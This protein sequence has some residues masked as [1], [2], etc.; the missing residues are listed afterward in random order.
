MRFNYYLTPSC[1]KR[2]HLVRKVPP[3][4]P[5]ARGDKDL[6]NWGGVVTVRV[7]SSLILG[8][9]DTEI[10]GTPSY[11]TG[12]LDRFSDSLISCL[13]GMRL[14]CSAPVNVISYGVISLWVV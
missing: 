2:A 3:S 4:S 14:P 1:S 6:S 9:L 7:Q 10:L 5:A 11:C 13:L 8:S 12:H